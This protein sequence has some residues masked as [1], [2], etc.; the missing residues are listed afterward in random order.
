MIWK[1]FFEYIFKCVGQAT[2]IKFIIW[3][4][5]IKITK[6]ILEPNN[7]VILDL[8][9]LIWSDQTRNVKYVACHGHYEYVLQE[10]YSGQ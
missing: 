2:Y 10:K 1:F 3:S 6:S 8:I 9:I 7:E 5:H 4:D